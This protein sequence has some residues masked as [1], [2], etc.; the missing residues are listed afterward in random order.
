MNN[1]TI[2]DPM[3]GP[4]EEPG[5]EHVLEQVL[6]HLLSRP[7]LLDVV[8]EQA[9]IATL[10][11]EDGWPVAVTGVRPAQEELL[12]DQRGAVVELSDGSSFAVLIEVLRRATEHS[13]VAAPD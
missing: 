7:D 9:T 12:T 10:V 8:G 5:H 2:H 4:D 3:H 13:T 11:G 1:D 6:M